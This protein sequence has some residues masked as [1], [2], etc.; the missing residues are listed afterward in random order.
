MLYDGYDEYMAI[1]GGGGSGDSGESRASHHQKD[2]SSRKSRRQKGG[3]SRRSREDSGGIGNT[4]REEGEPSNAVGN[5]PQGG[6]QTDHEDNG[7]SRPKC[8][9]DELNKSPRKGDHQGD[10]QQADVLDVEG[11]QKKAFNKKDKVKSEKEDMKAKK[12]KTTTTTL[13]KKLTKTKPKQPKEAETGKEKGGSKQKKSKPAA[14][15]GDTIKATKQKQPNEGAQKS[16]E[17]SERKNIKIS[18]KQKTLTSNRG[19]DKTVPKSKTRTNKDKKAAPPHEPTGDTTGSVPDKD[20]KQTPRKRQSE[21]ELACEMNY[22]KS[23]FC[24]VA[25]IFEDS[26]NQKAD[27]I[28]EYMKRRG[29]LLIAK[30]PHLTSQKG[31]GNCSQDKLSEA[32]EHFRSMMKQAKF[33]V[34]IMTEKVKVDSDCLQFCSYA[35]RLLK[36]VFPLLLEGSLDYGPCSLLDLLIGNKYHYDIGH[37]Y[38]QEMAK[39]LLKIK[40]WLVN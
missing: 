34:I 22:S 18:T 40:D 21:T 4:P 10:N 17:E 28:S 8:I 36:P 12:V 31:S 27:Q 5:T 13:N 6:G 2:G 15:A 3:E 39:F 14:A 37:Q 25:I 24:D 19:G 7:E 9:E 16:K 29:R 26:I 23:L 11:Q 33:V 1:A 35:D 32:R 30:Q 38:E 20:S